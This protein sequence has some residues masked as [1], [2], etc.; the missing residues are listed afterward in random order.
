MRFGD[1]VGTLMWNSSHHLQC[2]HAIGCMGAVLHTCNLRLGP[3][4]LGYT[5]R[6]AQDKVMFLDFD[7]MELLAKVDAG[8]LDQLKLYVCVGEDGV[9]GKFAVP[10]AIPA[11]RVQDHILYMYIYL[12]TL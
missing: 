2:Y 12:V 11:A 7:L 6:H 10:S 4:D 9:A 8:I 5:I 3:K 1:R